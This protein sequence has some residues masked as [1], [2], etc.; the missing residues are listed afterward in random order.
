MKATAEIISQVT[1]AASEAQQLYDY[2][3]KEQKDADRAISDIMHAA[4]FYTLNAAQGYK[5]YKMLKEERLRRREAKDALELL[6]YIRG[7][8]GGG[9][10]LEKKLHRV[11][12]KM[13]NRTYNPRVLVE[14]FQNPT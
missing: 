5:L 12:K 8:I 6:T 3:R 9:G 1:D 13:E 4:E 10:V 7:G 2:Y 11:M 14:L